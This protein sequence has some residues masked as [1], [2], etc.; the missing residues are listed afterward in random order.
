MYNTLLMTRRDSDEPVDIHSLD[1]YRT[2]DIL[3]AT[4][5][6]LLSEVGYT[7][8]KVPIK[9]VLLSRNASD[10][11]GELS[12]RTQTMLPHETHLANQMI[13]LVVREIGAL[14]AVDRMSEKSKD[15]IRGFQDS[16]NQVNGR[17]RAGPRRI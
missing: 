5:H 12:G 7:G 11:L 2:H 3:F 4:R 6:I 8:M 15:A 9:P 10:L 17:R 13:L 16:L 1:R 14:R